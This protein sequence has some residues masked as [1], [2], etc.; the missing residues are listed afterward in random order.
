MHFYT[1]FFEPELP[2]MYIHA[3]NDVKYEDAIGS[4]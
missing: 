3:M 2:V 4:L 1:N